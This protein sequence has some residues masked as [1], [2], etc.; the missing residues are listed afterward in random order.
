[1][2]KRIDLVNNLYPT[3]KF[4]GVI[5]IILSAFIVPGWKYSYS[6]F[7]VCA[8]IALGSGKLKSYLI[9]TV[10]SLLVLILLIFLMQ[11][12]LILLKEIFY[13]IGFINI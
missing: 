4:I 3:T 6:I 5:V 10:N 11:S 9:I 1:M 2:S 8:L 12:I 7:F 13:K